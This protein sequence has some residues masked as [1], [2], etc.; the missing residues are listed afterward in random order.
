MLNS[1]PAT[2]FVVQDIF[3]DLRRLRLRDFLKCTVART[4][5]IFHEATDLRLPSEFQI[6]GRFRTHEKDRKS[7]KQLSS[8]EA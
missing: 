3:R 1:A 8:M 6:E 2:F 5:A 4:V 7:I